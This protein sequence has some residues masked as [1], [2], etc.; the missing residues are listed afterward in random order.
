MIYICLFPGGNTPI[1]F[2]N[3]ASVKKFKE[4]H[5]GPSVHHLFCRCSIMLVFRPNSVEKKKKKNLLYNQS[6]LQIVGKENVKK[7][8]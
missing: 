6:V 7:L 3:K 1:Y 2:C 4:N 8:G 5:P